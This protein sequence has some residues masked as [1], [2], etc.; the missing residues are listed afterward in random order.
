MKL[1]RTELDKGI[2]KK[3]FDI[4]VKQFQF[5]DLNFYEKLIQ[6]KLTAEQNSSGYYISG[7]LK[8][9][10][11]QTCD[12]CLTSFQDLKNTDF[13]FLFTDKNE[14]LQDDS[15]DIIYLSKDKHEIDFKSI[16]SE[17]IFLEK[18]IKS[19]CKEDCRGL[20]YHCGTNLNDGI[21]GCPIDKTKDNLWEELKILKGK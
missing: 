16:F 8:I 19:L 6:C 13:K 20:C 1:Y 10:F 7:T 11:E 18:Q 2:T 9:P 15:D 17:I 5:D 14:L 21:C 3:L 4:D 12:R